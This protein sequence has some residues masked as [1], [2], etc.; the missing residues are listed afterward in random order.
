MCF[1]RGARASAGGFTPIERVVVL[2]LIGLLL[3][4][5]APRYFHTIDRGRDSMLRQHLS[6]I[7]D[8]I[9]KFHGDLRRYPDSLD[10]PV[11]RRDPRLAP[12]DP[13]TEQHSCTTVT[14]AAPAQDAVY[15][16]QPTATPASAA[17]AVGS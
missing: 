11:T 10:E 1:S 12:L 2:N 9:D 7:R 4:I 16:V 17:T 13:T 3:T 15:D 14:P 6:T 5:A 8:A